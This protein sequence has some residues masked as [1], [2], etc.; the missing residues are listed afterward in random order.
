M[1]LNNFPTDE[2]KVSVLLCVFLTLFILA[3]HPA[4]ESL[5][6]VKKQELLLKPS[7]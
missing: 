2:R 1:L 5:L 4:V 7:L 3:P 6:V